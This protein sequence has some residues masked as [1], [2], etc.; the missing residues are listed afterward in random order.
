MPENQ[1]LK[2]PY[3]EAQKIE[4][5]LKPLGFEIYECNIKPGGLGSYNFFLHVRFVGLSNI[6]GNNSSSTSADGEE[7]GIRQNPGD[8]SDSLE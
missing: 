5:A 7:S 4:D 8:G 1:E 2:S 6:S 3:A